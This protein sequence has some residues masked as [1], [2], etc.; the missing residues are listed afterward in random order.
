MKNSEYFSI[1]EAIL[2]A[3]G[4]PVSS[5]RIATALDIAKDKAN[6]ILSEFEKWYNTD[7]KGIQ[8]V[9]LGDSYQLCTKKEYEQYIK[10]VF[11]LKKQTPLSQAALE[12]LAIIAYNQPVTKSFVEQIRGVDSSS[13]INGLSEKGLIEE[14]GRL[15][16]P[17]R[18]IAYKTTYNFL[19][20]FNMESLEDL[21]KIPNIEE[22][23]KKDSSA[24]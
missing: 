14:A 8:V 22:N 18:P 12:T 23:E 7:E 21:P 4:E 17:G 11:Q 6:Q 9:K 24:E 2:F 13:I 10:L 15:E 1:I 3:S 16:V 5:D 19:R 20:S